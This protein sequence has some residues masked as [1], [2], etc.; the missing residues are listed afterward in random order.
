MPLSTYTKTHQK[1]LLTEN[2]INLENALKR[3]EKKMLHTHKHTHRGI[4]KFL[5]GLATYIVQA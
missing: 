5:L 1:Y 3:K 4:G 2:E